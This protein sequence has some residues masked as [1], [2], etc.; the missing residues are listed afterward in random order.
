MKLLNP[1]S[2]SLQAAL[3]L[4]CVML[5]V[6]CKS[7]EKSTALHSS[8]DIMELHTNATNKANTVESRP[9][10]EN[11]RSLLDMLRTIPGLEIRGN[12]PNPNILLRGTTSFLGENRPLF[13]LN[14]TPIGHDFQ[15]VNSSVVVQEIKRV[16][17]LKGAQA[18]LYGSRGANG[19]ILIR[20][21]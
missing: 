1:L 3:M 19:V 14:S 5:F 17:V 18:A 16:E 15:S 7:T 13:V 12:G 8:T 10:T 9:E 6:Q 21:K 20:T 4:V 11:V 2:I